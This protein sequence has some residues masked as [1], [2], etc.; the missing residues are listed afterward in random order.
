MGAAPAGARVRMSGPRSSLAPEPFTSVSTSVRWGAAPNQAVHGPSPRIE[1]SV[2]PRRRYGFAT[3]IRRRGATGTPRILTGAWTGLARLGETTSTT[4]G[5][6]TGGRAS[7][8]LSRT[9]P[10][11]VSGAISEAPRLQ[12]A[13][14]MSPPSPQL[15]EDTSMRGGRPF[16]TTDT[17]DP[18]RPTLG[19]TYSLGRPEEASAGGA[20]TARAALPARAARPRAASERASRRRCPPLAPR[21]PPSGAL[22]AGLR[23][24]G[25]LT[26][27]R[28]PCRGPEGAPPAPGLPCAA[29]AG[30]RRTSRRRARGG[31]R[32]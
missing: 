7:T 32:R 16:A 3:V 1:A 14:P 26:P 31:R 5:Q 25:E 4:H 18:T 27:S 24:H 29:C 20:R 30:G 15:W 2:T 10:D 8:T 22:H 13:E 21:T 6:G 12:P 17:T 9:R 23:R 11:G 28:P 19:R